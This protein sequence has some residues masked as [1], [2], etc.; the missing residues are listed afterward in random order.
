MD[1]MKNVWVYKRRGVKSWWV[2]WYESGKREAK[3]LPT[4]K[5]AENYCQLKYVGTFLRTWS[6]S[7]V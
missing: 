2:G 5:L 3:A 1:I 4:R 6:D 7:L